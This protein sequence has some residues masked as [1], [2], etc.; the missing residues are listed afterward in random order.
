MIGND[1]TRWH[2]LKQ[3]ANHIK[4]KQTSHHIWSMVKEG[5]HNQDLSDR[6]T[7]GD[8]CE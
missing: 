5:T 2:D 3:I 1:K 6:I 4:S 7:F 8:S